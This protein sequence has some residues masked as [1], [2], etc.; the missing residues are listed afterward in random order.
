MD[1]SPV[2][3]ITPRQHRPACRNNNQSAANLYNRQR[4]A[5]KRKDVRAHDDGRD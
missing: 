5:E 1:L 2:H 3:L 4:D